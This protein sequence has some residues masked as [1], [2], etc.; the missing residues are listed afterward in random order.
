M[1]TVTGD[2]STWDAAYAEGDETR[3]WFQAEPRTSLDLLGAAGVADSASVIDVGGGAARLV[4]ALLAGG[5]RDVAVLDLSA[6]ALAVA[7]RRLGPAAQQVRW[8]A[9]DLRTWRSPRTYDVWHDRAVLHF[10]T[11]EVDRN[12]YRDALGSATAVGSVAVIGCFAPG[13]PATCS[14]LPVRH[15]DA[16]GVADLLGDGWQLV[17]DT[18]ERHRTPWGAEQPFTWAVLRRVA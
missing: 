14:G 6:T 11:S 1:E 8:I 17:A 5:H 16:G 18:A 10:M 4:D 13:G 9:A 2:A 3:S 15:Y 12:S 7:R